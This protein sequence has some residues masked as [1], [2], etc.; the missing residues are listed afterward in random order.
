MAPAPNKI[1]HLQQILAERFPQAVPHRWALWATGWEALDA[2]LDGGLPQGAITELIAP[3]NGSALAFAALLRGAHERNYFVGLIDGRDS[4]DPDSIGLNEVL[5][6]LL[7]VRCREAAQAVKAADLL[8]RDGN[9][10]L[11]ILDLRA[12]PE[13]QIRKIPATV[14]YRLQRVAEPGV[15]AF[16]V[17]TPR[18]LVSSAQLKLTLHGRVLSSALAGMEVPRHELDECLNIEVGRSRAANGGFSSPQMLR[19]VG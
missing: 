4:F 18:S 15:T 6:H 5:A 16:L 10:P 8:L 7:W 2:R 11:L 17:V 19:E 3:E 14:W 12:N 9:L 1:V 13:T